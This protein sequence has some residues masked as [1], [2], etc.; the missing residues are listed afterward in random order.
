MRVRNRIGDDHGKSTIKIRYR[1]S[2][3][4][5]PT[6]KAVKPVHEILINKFTSYRPKSKVQSILSVCIQ[7]IG[8]SHER[9]RICL[10]YCNLV[11][12]HSLFLFM[13]LFIVLLLIHSLFRLFSLLAQYLTIGWRN[14]LMKDYR[15]FKARHWQLPLKI[16]AFKLNMGDP[17]LTQYLS[18]HFVFFFPTI[19][20]IWLLIF[21]TIVPS[22]VRSARDKS[23]A[24]FNAQQS[25]KN[26]LKAKPKRTKSTN[27]ES[28]QLAS[29]CQPKW[30]ATLSWS[31]QNCWY[32]WSFATDKEPC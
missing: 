21:F 23:W 14:M 5:K 26:H 15:K 7:S 16:R 27:D 11:E 24:R 2:G 18:L 31:T 25:S 13:F 3:G 6:E 28:L 9:I 4:C 32:C 12:L 30:F 19:Q 29:Y 20:T 8:I 1:I 10:R 17:V 22:C